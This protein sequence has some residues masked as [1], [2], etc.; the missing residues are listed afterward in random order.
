VIR[1]W[2][3][4]VLMLAGC[5]DWSSLYGD[6]GSGGDGGTGAIRWV[7]ARSVHTIATDVV[8]P[9]P[10]VIA[11]DV[12]VAGL[13]LSHQT[14]VLGAPPSGWSVLADTTDPCCSYYHAAWLWKRATSGEPS[15]YTFPITW[16]NGQGDDLSAVVIAFRGAGPI[17]RANLRSCPGGDGCKSFDV[18]APAPAPGSR[19]ARVVFVVHEVAFGGA[20]S[21]DASVAAVPSS[22]SDDGRVGLFMG[23][24]TQAVTVT[25]KTPGPTA[26]ESIVL[27]AA[28]P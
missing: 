20:A 8:L 22:Q 10:S 7:D 6:G 11:D 18:P 27:P 24:E 15:S 17:E 5:L 1:L 9:A 16:D 19:D 12:L 28:A 2:L 25:C 4:S 13:F 23:G 14:A 26:A 21:C 3:G